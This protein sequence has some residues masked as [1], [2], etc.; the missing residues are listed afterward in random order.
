MFQSVHMFG[1]SLIDIFK[2][3]FLSY[4]NTAIVWPTVNKKKKW[5]GL[6]WP[7]TANCHLLVYSTRN[8]APYPAAP[9]RRG[10]NYQSQNATSFLTSENCFVNDLHGYQPSAKI[11]SL[12]SYFR[13]N[14]KRGENLTRHQPANIVRSCNMEINV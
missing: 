11:F 5:C 3:F 1:G 4:K 2:L 10:K 12:L 8:K 13:Y 7:N 14:Q 6:V 9:L